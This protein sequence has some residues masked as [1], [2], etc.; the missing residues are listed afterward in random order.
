[1]NF[2]YSLMILLLLLSIVSSRQNCNKCSTVNGCFA[3]CNN[4]N[5]YFLIGTW[6]LCKAS[7]QL[8]GTDCAI[9]TSQRCY[10]AS[11]CDNI[12]GN[13]LNNFGIND[14][15]FDDYINNNNNKFNN[16]Y[17]YNFD[18]S[19]GLQGYII[20]VLSIL[21]IIFIAIILICVSNYFSNKKLSY[22]KVLNYEN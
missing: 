13:D 6:S 10:C 5:N 3:E 14:Y 8:K 22:N 9:Y 1:M 2:I 16:N 18:W 7:C 12:K 15:D 19:S 17:L 21:S 4:I 20:G 11:N